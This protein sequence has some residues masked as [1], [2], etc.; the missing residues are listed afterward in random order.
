MSAGGPLAASSAQLQLQ[1]VRL[2]FD[3]ESEVDAG[4]N[5]GRKLRHDFVVLG[6]AEHKLSLDQGRYTASIKVPPSREQA[7]HEAVALWVTLRGDLRPL[8]A[9]G[10]WL[11]R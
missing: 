5:R 11:T 6:Y 3:L 1:V 7:A 9:T 10:G 2:G 4:E 8:Q